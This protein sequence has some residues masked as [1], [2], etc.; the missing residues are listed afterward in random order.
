MLLAAS[1][2]QV[3]AGTSH[4]EEQLLHSL[5]SHPTGKGSHEDKIV[6]PKSSTTQIS[7]EMTH[8][9]WVFPVPQVEVAAASMATVGAS[10]PNDA[11]AIGGEASTVGV[12]LELQPPSRYEIVA[13]IATEEGI[14]RIS[15][16]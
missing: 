6:P 8:C 11:S 9:V 5:D 2:S 7:A 4:K 14:R 1:S 12:E 3:S 15:R 13:S 10:V 16:Y